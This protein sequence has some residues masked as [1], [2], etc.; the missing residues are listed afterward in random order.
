MAKPAA[1]NSSAQM[2]KHLNWVVSDTYLL[3]IKTHG[4]HWNVTGPQFHQLHLLFE[5]QY[6][7]LFT[8]ADEVAE[9][10]RA[11]DAYALGSTQAF[12][13]HTSVKE[14]NENPP[15]AAA[16][17]KDLVKSN[18]QVRDRVSEARRFA[19]EVED[20]ASEDLM[21]KRLEA[22]DKALWMLRS[23]LA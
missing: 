11:L 22:H 14:A 3:M 4:Y 18:E 17:I 5:T 9:R 13:E 21:N 12:R 20:T 6:N 1:K 19:N 10:V 2:A 15:S 16:M 8:A 7:E 23:L